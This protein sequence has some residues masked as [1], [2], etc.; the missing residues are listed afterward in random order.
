[1][2]HPSSCLDSSF[3]LCIWRGVFFPPCGLFRG[4]FL[5]KEKN[6]KAGAAPKRW[7]RS[8]ADKGGGTQPQASLIPKTLPCGGAG[9]GP[10]AG[11]RGWSPGTVPEVTVIPPCARVKIQVDPSKSERLCFNLFP[12]PSSSQGWVW[13]RMGPQG[14]DP[15]APSQRQQQHQTCDACVAPAWNIT[16]FGEL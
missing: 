1:M 14:H 5:K 8:G 13:I 6:K 4:R 7:E 16:G 10:Q 3:V 15:I 11:S 12:P 2:F 9:W